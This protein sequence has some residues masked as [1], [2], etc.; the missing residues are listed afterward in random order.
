MT[1]RMPI[2][3]S[4]RLVGALLCASLLAVAGLFAQSTLAST[5]ARTA[6]AFGGAPSLHVSGRG[7]FT[8]HGRRVVLHGVNFPG[9]EFLCAKGRGIWDGPVDQASVTAMRSWH[10]NAVRVPLNEDC[11]N[12][13]PYLKLRY[14]GVVYQRAV[15][16]Y[17]QLLNR[18]GLVA[19]LD[20]HR[21]DGRYA[22][23]GAHCKTT[24]K[25][26]CMKPMP[27]AAHAI[28][29]WISVARTF[30]TNNAVIFDA[31]NEPFPN[32]AP[33][34]AEA[35]AWQCW[36]LGGNCT[37]IGYQVAGMQSL[38]TA[39]RSTGA[40]N[41][42]MLPGLVYAN[43]LSGWLAHE[44]RDPD[45]NIAASWHIY[46][47]NPCAGRPCWNSQVAPVIA[48]VPVV[49]GEFGETNCADNR[50]NPLM[51]WLDLRGTGYLAWAWNATW[52]CTV[53]PSLIRSWAGAPTLYGA[54]YRQHLLSLR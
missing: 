22:G 25:A 44:P 49:V 20:L 26:F 19:I 7:L 41:V 6:V 8:A 42:I 5:N 35:E 28:P 27:D 45:H 4:A 47:W 23:P 9:A 11:W 30:K 37:G 33:G 39:I 43:D 38:V 2:G 34:A 50:I 29:F 52:T 46:P 18:N 13:E 21:S 17:V 48:R 24:V 36:Q 32:R 54:G 53:G 1:S 16:A 51:R 12:G 3:R 15:A 10:V 14:R 40:R 31:F